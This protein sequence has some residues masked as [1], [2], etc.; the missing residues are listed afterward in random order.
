MKED[1]SIAKAIAIVLEK[2]PHL[3]FVPCNLFVHR[4]S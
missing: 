1:I 4:L 3:R 2:N